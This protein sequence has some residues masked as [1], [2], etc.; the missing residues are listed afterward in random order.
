MAITM[1]LL[2]PESP[3]AEKLHTDILSPYMKGQERGIDDIKSAMNKG[4][5]LV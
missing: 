5:S 3:L 1:A 2:H 4:K